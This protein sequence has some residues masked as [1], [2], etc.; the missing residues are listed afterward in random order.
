MIRRAR[1]RA[2]SISQANKTAVKIDPM[3]TVPPAV[4]YLV[5]AQSGGD[6]RVFHYPI[7]DVF[8]GG[9]VLKESVPR[10]RYFKFDVGDPAQ[11][12]RPYCDVLCHEFAATETAVR[13]TMD[14]KTDVV[15]VTIQA[16]KQVSSVFG[17]A[18]YLRRNLLPTVS[19]HDCVKHFNDL[20]KVTFTL[21][22]SDDDRGH[23]VVLTPGRWFIGMTD[24]RIDHDNTVCV[25]KQ[26]ITAMVWTCHRDNVM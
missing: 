10:W 1:S 19:S 26:E 11:W 3:S 25:R 7:L 6:G 18:V 12:E 21:S 20:S 23:D 9:N 8:T 2:G 4:M 13:T 24:V 5:D 22:S 16:D 17:A 15:K 14:P